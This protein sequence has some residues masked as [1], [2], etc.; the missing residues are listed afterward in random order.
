MAA[1]RGKPQLA[2]PTPHPS[3][4]LG[5]TDQR[6]AVASDKWPWASIGRVNVL[7]GP[8]N[9]GFCTGTLTGLRQVV[10]AAHCLFNVRTD[11][12]AK[13]QSMHF[14]VG[15]QGERIGGHS[16]VE[17]YFVPPELKI[18]NEDRPRYDSM[19]LGML[20]N[21]WAILTL[22]ESLETKPVPIRALENGPLPRSGGREVVAAAGYGVDR[23]FMLSV[24][25][26]CS[27]TVGAPAP[28]LITHECDTMPGE[29]GGPLLLLQDNNASLIGIVSGSSQRFQ[30][31][32][33]YRA[34]KGIGVSASAFAPAA[35]EVSH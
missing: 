18:R 29:S 23:Q 1:D 28:D 9:R 6:Q 25:R 31:Q 7:F 3:G 32:I 21:D 33:G 27:A 15:Q 2:Q 10:T 5:A 11:E 35:A 30:P 16:L 19:T 13:P 4:I 20:R 12:W 17:K 22:Q 34:I 26:G 14:L 8:A 24:D